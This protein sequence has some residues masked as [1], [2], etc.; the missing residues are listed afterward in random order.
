VVVLPFHIHNSE[1]EE[2]QCHSGGRFAGPVCHRSPDSSVA[3]RCNLAAGHRYCN[4][5]RRS[6]DCLVQRRDDSVVGCSGPLAGGGW[7]G[8][9]VVVS[10]AVALALELSQM[11]PGER[12]PEEY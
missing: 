5:D 1:V 2:N 11:D 7:W 3:P 8:G 9:E 10:V 6:A 12:R 4:E